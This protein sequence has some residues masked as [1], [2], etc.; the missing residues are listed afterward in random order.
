MLMHEIA[1]FLCTSVDRISMSLY[2]ILMNQME[3][4]TKPQF[5]IQ[6]NI[7]K[8]WLYNDLIEN[9]AFKLRLFW[10]TTLKW[11]FLVVSLKMGYLHEFKSDWAEKI[12]NRKENLSSFHCSIKNDMLTWN[13]A[14]KISPQSLGIKKVEKIMFRMRGEHWD[15]AL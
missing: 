1:L 11:Y 9:K 14:E 15:R 2:P 5:W 4:K 8:H 13:Y 3:S 10:K 7:N 12:R 6:L